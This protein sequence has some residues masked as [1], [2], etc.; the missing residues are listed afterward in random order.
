L[1]E[2]ERVPQDLFSFLGHHGIAR[3]KGEIDP[4]IQLTGHY[5]MEGANSMVK[6]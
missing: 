5:P 2:P 1:K 3:K 6:S 4:K